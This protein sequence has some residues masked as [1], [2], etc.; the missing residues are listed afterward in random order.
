[1]TASAHGRTSEV[2]TRAMPLVAILAFALT[3]ACSGP[4]GPAPV[5]A[6][7]TPRADVAAV[8]TRGNPGAYTFSVTVRS[9]ETGCDR[10]ADWWEVLREDGRL[11]YR[12]IL[13]HSHVSEQ[14]FTRSGGPVPANA[15]ETLVVRAHL[16]PGGYV[17]AAL[18]GSV[19]EGF[20]AWTPPVGFAAD[21]ESA[22]PQ[23]DDCAF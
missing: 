3:S 17:G 21:V 9:D 10:Y 19:A 18:R 7:S 13:A 4:T 23:P 1:M 12:R 16:A 14:P 5:D 20:S 2:M 8:S 15:E 6:Q 22:P 11:A